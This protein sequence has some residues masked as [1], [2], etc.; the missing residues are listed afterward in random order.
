M[1]IPIVSIKGSVILPRAFMKIIFV[2][3]KF[4]KVADHVMGEQHSHRL[5]ACIQKEDE[6]DLLAGKTVIGSICKMLDLQKNG[7]KWIGFVLGISPSKIVYDYSEDLVDFGRITLIEEINDLEEEEYQSMQNQLFNLIE[8]Y[9]HA[10]NFKAC[11]SR[12]LKDLN[13]ED[14][15]GQ[16]G[17]YS[18]IT[19]DFK[20]KLLKTSSLRKRAQLL[21][22]FLTDLVPQS[23]VVPTQ[24]REN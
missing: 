13:L 21:I 2:N 4:R 17:S 9:Q 22:D 11:S 5:F 19:T 7:D 20:K 18:P 1:E 23:V 10:L 16:F 24:V 8:E 14:L 6:R 15:I 12:N 3:E